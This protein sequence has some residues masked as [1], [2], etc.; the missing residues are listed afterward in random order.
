MGKKIED[1]I[2]SLVEV[3]KKIVDKATNLSSD[4]KGTELAEVTSWVTRLGQIVRNLYGL[5]SQQYSNYKLA[6]ETENFYGIHSNWCS[7]VSQ[8]FGIA[9]SVKHDL[10]HDLLF[11][12]RVLMQADIFADFLEMGEYLLNEGYKDAS[13]VIIGTVLE[14]SLRKLCENNNIPTTKTSGAPLTIDP[15]NSALVKNEV[16]NK[17]VQKQI[18]T[19]AHIRN[20]AAH[21]EY[22]EY[23]TNETKMMLLFVQSFVEQHL[24]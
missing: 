15:L 6:L 10:E 5:D 16:Y 14:N 17:L 13:A 23:D 4:M 9:I 8:M 2:N 1:E 21:G 7:Q 18:T 20:K 24:K 12:I 3:G 19:W 22:D 11:N